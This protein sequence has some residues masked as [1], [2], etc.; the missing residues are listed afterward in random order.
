MTSLARAIG[1]LM[2]AVGILGVVS[3]DA[4]LAIVSY[5]ATAL[6]LW[7]VAALRVAVGLVLVRA[8]SRSRAPRALRVL[9]FV[10]LVAGLITPFFGVERARVVLEWLTARGP[11]LTRLWGAVAIA[12]GA[13]IAYAAAP[14]RR[15]R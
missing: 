10:V 5:S 4:L 14:A 8:A 13:S 7:V 9:G 3:P 11:G 2:A 6:G 1:V 15:A 12:F